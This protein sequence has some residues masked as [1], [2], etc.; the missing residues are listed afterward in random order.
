MGKRIV[1]NGFLADIHCTSESN[2]DVEIDASKL[3]WSEYQSLILDLEDLLSEIDEKHSVRSW[4]V[5]GRSLR[6]RYHRVSADERKRRLRFSP[7]PSKFSNIITNARGFVYNLVT[8]YCIVL[9]KVG[10]RKVYFL[11]KSVAPSLVAS[12]DALNEKVI[13]KLRR[14]IKEFQESNDYARIGQCLHKHKIDPRVLDRTFW[15]GNFMV[16]V[17]PVDFGYSISEDEYYRKVK[18]Q[19]AVRELDILRKHIERKYREYSA[20]AVKNIMEKVAV[21]SEEFDR[22][23]NIQ[24]AFKDRLDKLIELSKSIGLN[25]VSAFLTK[26]RKIC[27]LPRKERKEALEKT[28]GV[29]T[30][31]EAVKKHLSFLEDKN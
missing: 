21:M 30:L 28:F 11:P 7:F 13:G 2:L 29:K 12:I 14:E 18:R 4:L 24:K 8:Q 6:A 27:D 10:N 17:I 16:D 9:E 15:I 5:R 20:E 3:T 19:S 25:E 1:L 26:V 31:S 22:R 23:K